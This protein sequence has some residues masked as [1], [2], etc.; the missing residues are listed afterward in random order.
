MYRRQFLQ[1][2]NAMGASIVL[3]GSAFYEEGSSV[4]GLHPLQ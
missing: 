3:P 4:I 2:L 1:T